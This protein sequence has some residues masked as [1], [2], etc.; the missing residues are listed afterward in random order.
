MAQLAY[1]ARQPIVDTEGRICGY[2]LLY[3]D[4][5]VQHAR[6]QSNE[7][8]TA[9]VLVN[10]LSNVGFDALTYGKPA[11]INFNEK[12]LI[13][14]YGD[15]LPPQQ[16]VLELLEGSTLS[17][18][19]VERCR[20]L[21]NEGYR[22]ALDD[23]S[24]RSADADLLELVGTIKLDVQAMGG[25]LPGTW[26]SGLRARGFELL[27]EKVETWDS[28]RSCRA[29]GCTLFQGFFF[30][31]PEVLSSADLRPS[32][33]ALIEALRMLGE[34]APL[35]D[36][37]AV[38]S[39][40]M[41]LMYKILRYANSAAFARTSEITTMRG[42]FVLLG[43]NRLRVWLSLLL[44]AGH[45]ENPAYN[46]LFDVARLR[47]ALMG[48]CAEALGLERWLCNEAWVVGSFSLLEA[49]LGIPMN[50]LVTKLALP[51]YM[52]EALLH[53][54][55]TLGRILHLVRLLEG[56]WR[57]E[58]QAFAAELGLDPDR[59]GDLQIKAMQLTVGL[60]SE[61]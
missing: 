43:R 9:S 37:E 59:L 15:L 8:A 4:A 47:S 22:L 28:F 45:T 10:V 14:G 16:V 35:D 36:I 42:A 20:A 19:L 55:G 58:T 53:E 6:I 44:Y 48:V 51:R 32:Q 11:Y 24:I 5:A 61:P 54:A 3:R 38:L 23:Y 17:A 52:S 31:R 60:T 40:D 50:Q 27:A 2:E 46:V 41:E 26:V 33:L 29:M 34:E 25:T 13:E 18:D 57:P 49:L 12:F 30:A 7:Q 39:R 1:I 21:R 56:S